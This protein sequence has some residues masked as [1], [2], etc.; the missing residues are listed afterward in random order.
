MIVKTFSGPTVREALQKVRD[1]FGSDAVIL[2]TR[3][4]SGRSGRPGVSLDSVEVTAAVEHERTGLVAEGPRTLH[5]RGA[6]A[7][8]IVPDALPAVAEGAE[9]LPPATEV[10]AVN[11]PHLQL[12]PAI[13]QLRQIADDL[14]SV[15]SRDSVWAAMRR[16]LPTQ[17]ALSES[18]YETFAAHLV[19]SLPPQQQFL[20]GYPKGIATLILGARGAGKSTFLF[21]GLAARWQSTQRKPTL[22]VLSDAADH[23][24]ERLKGLCDGCGV[25]FSSH[26]IDRTRRLRIESRGRGEDCFTE[27]V[28]GSLS[29]DL[30]DLARRVRHA[31]NPDV[32]V[33]VVSATTAPH[34]WRQQ[35]ERFAPFR[36]THLAV[37]QWDEYQPWWDLM[38]FSG[39]NG[40]LLS[41][42]TKGSEAFG[43][44]EPFTE[45]DLRVGLTG[46]ISRQ[47]H[48]AD[49]GVGGNEAGR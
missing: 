3:V 39:Q 12:T 26:H 10:I 22:T 24:Q 35:L 20:N 33:L 17:S 41:Y 1:A 34:V 7:P 14:A 46:H 29:P 16:W 42:R 15:T 32:T 45:T 49:S 40:L 5:V 31:V 25:E 28:T 23:G 8:D 21:K 4:E 38:M 13:Q 36:P 2:D 18:L 19:E 11:G 37:S 27:L 48:R 6:L 30:D 9:E 43:E 44:I 47:M